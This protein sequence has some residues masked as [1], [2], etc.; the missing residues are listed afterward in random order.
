ME[1][2]FIEKPYLT[3]NLT[4]LQNCPRKGV[5]VYRESP[6]NVCFQLRGYTAKRGQYASVSL[7]KAQCLEIA[8]YLTKVAAELSEQG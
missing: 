3:F 1:N 7:S 8:D 2:L 4:E 6:V 5:R